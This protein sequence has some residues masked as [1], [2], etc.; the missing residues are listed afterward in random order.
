MNESTIVNVDV[1]CWRCGKEPYGKFQV[2]NSYLNDQEALIIISASCS[3]VCADCYRS[4]IEEE[5]Y[6][7]YITKGFHYLVSLLQF[8]LWNKE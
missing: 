7:E 8:N 4:I 2:D 3:F 6:V 1:S 5:K